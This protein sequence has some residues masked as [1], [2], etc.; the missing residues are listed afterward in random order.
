M[1][2]ETKLLMKFPTPIPPLRIQRSPFR[3]H[4]ALLAHVVHVSYMSLSTIFHGIFG[5]SIQKK[6]M[7]RMHADLFYA[8]DTI[9]FFLEQLRGNSL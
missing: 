7:P 8:V 2:V 9:A 3:K 4:S 1:G 5:Q 6:Q